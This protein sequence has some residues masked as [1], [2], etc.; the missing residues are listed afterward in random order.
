MSITTVLDS[1]DDQCRMPVTRGNKPASSAVAGES[2][3]SSPVT[4]SAAGATDS[5]G[6]VAATGARTGAT[7]RALAFT[8]RPRWPRVH[9]SPAPNPTANI[10]TASTI[11][12]P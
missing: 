2:S 10:T 1:A 9:H 11:A 3:L 7:G 6:T 12:R 8:E 4:P 5:A